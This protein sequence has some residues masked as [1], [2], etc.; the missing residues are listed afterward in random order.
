MDLSFGSLVDADTFKI[1][2][3]SQA[4]HD[5]CVYLKE[6]GELNIILTN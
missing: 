4:V 6:E 1:E 3:I 5:L 2:K